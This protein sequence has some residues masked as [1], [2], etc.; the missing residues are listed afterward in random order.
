MEKFARKP[1]WI[2]SIIPTGKEYNQLKKELNE[3]GLH[4]VCEEANC[5]NLGEC[6]KNKTATMMILGDTCTRGCRFCNV[7][8]GNPKG[9]VDIEEIENASKMVALMQLD[10]IVIT[11]VDRDDLDDFGANHFANVVSRIKD[12]HPNVLIEVLIPDFNNRKE[13]LDTLARSTPFVVAHNVE[14]IERLTKQVRDRRANYRQS[15]SVLKYFSDSYP[16]LV[17]KTSLM[18]GLGETK[19]EI[20]SS[21]KDL[22][23][24]GVKIV[25]L[26]QY[27]RPSV[28]NIAVEKYY[29]PEEFLE[30]K[31]IAEKMGFQ[32]VASGP[33]VRSSYRASDYY[34]FLKSKNGLNSTVT[35]L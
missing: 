8:T 22:L 26:G 19:D 13:S 5:P 9:I 1:S 18:L 24:A 25:T 30:Y 32:F 4:T 14:T 6:W 15:L 35:R 3:K 17:T 21:F 34:Q 7:K 23:D 27:L 10:Y 31:N 20:I 28:R 29:S 11:S 33:M 12:D 16:N 2:R